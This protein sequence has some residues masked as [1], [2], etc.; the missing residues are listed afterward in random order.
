MEK[1]DIAVGG[2]ALGAGILIGAIIG[3]LYAP[4]SGQETRKMVVDKVGEVKD[5]IS[6]KLK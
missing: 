5:K 1:K 2:I 4:R 3:L 6:E